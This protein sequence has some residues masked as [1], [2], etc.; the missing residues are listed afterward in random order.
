MYEYFA[1]QLLSYIIVWDVPSFYRIS[2][3]SL[4]LL[5]SKFSSSP[6]IFLECTSLFTLQVKVNVKVR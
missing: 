5:V 6:R 4:S 2:P 1:R 3:L